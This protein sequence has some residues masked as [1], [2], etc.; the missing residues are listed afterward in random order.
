[1]KPVKVAQIG[2]YHD[3]A[4]PAFRSLLKQKDVFDFIGFAEV[5]SPAPNPILSPANAAECAQVPQYTIEE[6]LAMDDLEAVVIECEEEKAT[7]VA[8]PFAKKG[9]AVYMDKPGSQNI[10]LFEELISVVQEKNL[11][12]QMGYMYRYNP[13]VLHLHELIRRGELGE[14]FSVEAHMDCF[15]KPGKRQWL[16]KHKGGMMYFLGCH[17]IDA[18]Y[19]IQGEPEEVIPMNMSTGIDGVTAEDYGFCVLRYKNGVSFAK[20]CACEVNGFLRRQLV[21]TGTKG[22]Y[23]I[24]P[25]EAL[26]DGAQYSPSRFA[27]L[28]DHVHSWGKDASVPLDFGPYDRYDAMMRD[29]AEIVRGK[30]NPYTPEYELNLFKLVMKCCG[31]TEPAASAKED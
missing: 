30:E 21:V 2:A 20:T 15:H 26:K 6:L 1:M 3:H 23:V 14:I 4:V 31:Y 19:R 29:F 24:E 7:A 5:P 8:L 28:T 18:I 13:S 17:L 16:D 12:F 27:P 11:P 25:W 22:T 9:V 10:A